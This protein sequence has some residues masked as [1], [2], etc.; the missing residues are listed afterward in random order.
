M[1]ID[2]GVAG[3]ES[4][5]NRA[6]LAFGLNTV[7]YRAFPETGPIPAAPGQPEIAPPRVTSAAAEPSPMAPQQEPPVAESRME[8]PRRFANE[9]PQPGPLPPGNTGFSL[10][11]QVFPA[12]PEKPAGPVPAF[13]QARTT[14]HQAAPNSPAHAAVTPDPAAF[15][16]AFA[17]AYNAAFGTAPAVTP[18]PEIPPAFRRA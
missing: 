1:T 4:D 9:R 18:A 12:A 15:G 13:S 6:C 8:P 16:I 17:S 14:L 2:R 3:Q 7:N 10:L 5:V 11:A